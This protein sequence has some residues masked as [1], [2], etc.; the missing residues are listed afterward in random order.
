LKKKIKYFD[1]TRDFTESRQ[2]IKNAWR[3]LDFISRVQEGEALDEKENKEYASLQDWYAKSYKTSQQW[4]DEIYPPDEKGKRALTIYDPDGW[5]RSNWEFSFEK[6]K[7]T[8]EEFHHR[9]MH[10]TCMAD[11]KLMEQWKAANENPPNA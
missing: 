2:T 6:E 11:K 10:S 3:L 7:I 4:Y 1:M 9:V 5:D 8:R